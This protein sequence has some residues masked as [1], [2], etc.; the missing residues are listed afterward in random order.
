MFTDSRRKKNLLLTWLDL[1]EAF[2]SVSYDLLSLMM[3]RLGLSGST[4]DIVRDIYTNAS[5]SPSARAPRISVDHLYTP[6]LGTDVIPALSWEERYKYLGCPTGAFRSNA[7]VLEELRQSLVK[8]TYCLPV[9]LGGMAEEDLHPLLLSISRP[10]DWDPER[11]ME[12]HAV[13][14]GQAFKFLADTRDPYIRAVALDQLHT[15]K[16]RA[17]HP[18]PQQTEDLSELPKQLV[19]PQGEG[20][21]GHAKHLSQCR[22]A[23]PLA[24]NHRANTRLGNTPY[25]KRPASVLDKAEQ[26]VP[27]PETGHEAASSEWTQKIHG[28]RQGVRLGSSAPGLDLLYIHRSIPNLPTVS[29]HTQSEAQPASCENGASP[30]SPGSP[31]NPMSFVWMC[32]LFPPSLGTKYKEQAIPGTTGNNRPDLTIISPDEST[33]TIVDVSCPFEGSP[34]AL[35]EAAKTS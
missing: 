10:K 19:R 16:K 26:I 22:I 17:R 7:K 4:L 6:R 14:A 18:R 31:F 3:E 20:G 25:C 21:E 8:D 32:G 15:V 12:S 9:A 23:L 28:P 33:V 5:S 2:P 24:G 35:E 11:R 27:S 1:R 13:K 29:I 34:L 30:M